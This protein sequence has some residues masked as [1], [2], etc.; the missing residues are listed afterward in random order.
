MQLDGEDDLTEALAKI[1]ASE[2][3]R[4]EAYAQFRTTL[5]D[6]APMEKASAWLSC[7]PPP[8]QHILAMQLMGEWKSQEKEALADYNATHLH[9]PAITAGDIAGTS[10]VRFRD[11][12][13]RSR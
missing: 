2:A 1:R 11:F 7:R 10:R 6:L 13:G 4:Q 8:R 9:R 5:A 3:E 12:S